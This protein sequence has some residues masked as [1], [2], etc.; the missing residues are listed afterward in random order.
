[1]KKIGIIS[2]ALV[3]ALGAL[4]VGFAAWSQNLIVSGNITAGSFDPQLTSVSVSDNDGAAV[5]GGTIEVATDP[6]QTSTSFTV[7]LDNVYPGY[8]GTVNFTVDNSGTSI[9]TSITPSFTTALSTLADYATITFTPSSDGTITNLD[10]SAAEAA[11]GSQAVT[12]TITIDGDN[13][14]QGLSDSFTFNCAVAQA[15]QTAG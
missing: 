12:M 15:V 1:M 10:L 11:G 7:N 9:P 5:N 8:V 14:F 2:L 6:E 13:A 4:G 3:L